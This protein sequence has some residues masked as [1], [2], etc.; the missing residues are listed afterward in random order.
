MKPKFSNKP[1]KNWFAGLYT[2]LFYAFFIAFLIL[3]MEF[4][5][6]KTATCGKYY[7]I[8]DNRPFFY[9]Y[10][11]GAIVFFILMKKYD[12]KTYDEV[13]KNLDD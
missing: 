9:F 2:G 7:L 8:D 3:G 6:I 13:E 11:I 1:R 4:L 5:E 12:K 10:L